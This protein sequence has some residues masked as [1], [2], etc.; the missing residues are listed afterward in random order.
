MLGSLFSYTCGFSW[1]RFQI[2]L[3]GLVLAKAIHPAW[4]WSPLYFQSKDTWGKLNASLPCCWRPGDVYD[5]RINECFSSI[6]T[7][8]HDEAIHHKIRVRGEKE[9][10]RVLHEGMRLKYCNR[11]VQLPELF[12]LHVSC[13]RWERSSGFIARQEARDVIQTQASS[14]GLIDASQV[15]S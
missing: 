1:K 3:I 9:G 5:L 10:P 13:L 8:E 12:F 11:D 15:T 7:N 14:R 6:N 4:H 2:Y